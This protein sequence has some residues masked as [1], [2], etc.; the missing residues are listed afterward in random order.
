MI[1]KLIQWRC[2]LLLAG[3]YEDLCRHSLFPH[4]I[5]IED[6]LL[7]IKT[8]EE[9]LAGMAQ[10]HRAMQARRVYACKA[11]VRAMEVPRD[12]RFRVWVRWDERSFDPAE[13]RSSEATY[14]FRE[15]GLGYQAEMLHFT[16]PSMPHVCAVVTE[17][18]QAM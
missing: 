6:Q 15:T 2:D 5:Y 10:M 1:K 9:M 14:F 7:V 3:R 16:R 11:H 4:A 12:G 13:N 8:P 17:S 18:A